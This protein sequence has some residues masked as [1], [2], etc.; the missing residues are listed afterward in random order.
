[1]DKHKASKRNLMFFLLPSTFLVSLISFLIGPAF[2]S[3]LGISYK[4]T[5][6]ILGFFI[7]LL[8][9]TISL[10]RKIYIKHVKA[11]NGSDNFI[12]N[13]S[14][15]FHWLI[16]AALA[17]FIAL[18]GIVLI[19]MIHVNSLK[20]L[21]WILLSLVIIILIFN[22]N[23][24]LPPKL[25]AYHPVVN[26]IMAFII[27]PFFSLSIGLP[28]LNPLFA[29]LCMPL[30]F[31]YLACVLAV[32]LENYAIDLKSQRLSIGLMLGWQTSIFLHD[33]YILIGFLFLAAVP[34]FG[35]SWSIVYPQLFSLPIGILQIW[36]LK[37][38]S[39]GKKPRWL[40]LHATTNFLIFF[41][42]YMLLFALWK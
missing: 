41:G 23:E 2:L 28:A 36:L 18:L 27:I 6:F 22:Q 4:R 7:L 39:D 29:L 26:G 31:I 15:E 12:K 35:I 13:T 24:I 38:I 14:I 10:L 11:K 1:M 25:L 16:L 33:F 3:Y 42:L 30:F 9:Q 5:D 32:E 17:F 20:A 37:Q 8:I 34:L 19:Q 21:T 40:I